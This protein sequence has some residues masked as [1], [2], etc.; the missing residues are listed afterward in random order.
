MRKRNKPLECPQIFL[1]PVKYYR[2]HAS[3]QYNNR[4]FSGGVDFGF[5]SSFTVSGNK[6]L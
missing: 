3:I 2:I 6:L 1:T 4:K 5:F